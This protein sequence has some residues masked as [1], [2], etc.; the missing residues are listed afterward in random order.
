[1][2]RTK[3][4]PSSSLFEYKENLSRIKR[5]LRSAP[6]DKKILSSIRLRDK[7]NTTFYSSVLLLSS[8][9]ERYIESVV[10]ETIDF[11]N[12]ENLTVKQIPEALRK[13]QIRENL[14]EISGHFQKE[15][16]QT[17][18]VILLGKL[19]NLL[20]THDWYLKE[21]E[22]M[23]KLSSDPLIGD[24]RFSNPSPDKIDILFRSLEIASITGKAVGRDKSPDRGAIREKVKELIEKRNNIAHTGGTV[25]VTKEDVAS[26]IDYCERLTKGIDFILGEKLKEIAGKWP[27]K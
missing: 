4:P 16:V 22:V 19:Q 7:A 13:S 1:M 10:V 26:Y 15:R 21:S 3:R 14:D 9:L 11:L 20:H 18:I 2:P 25:S 6:N 24:M 8:Y 12:S 23:N 27:W 5:F 17:N